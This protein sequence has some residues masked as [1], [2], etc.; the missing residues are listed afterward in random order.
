M[1]EFFNA[2]NKFKKRERKPYTVVIDGKT[3]EVSHEKSIE[4]LK[5]GIEKWMLNDDGNIVKKPI[6]TI[7]RQFTELVKA[8]KGYIFL[9]RDPFWPER[10]DEGGHVWQI[11][12]E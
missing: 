7:N 2:L 3:V 5:S 10:V 9:D 6:K 11:P 4:I 12:S 1:T 8:E